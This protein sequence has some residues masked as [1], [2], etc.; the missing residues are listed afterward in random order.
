M[1]SL[2]TKLFAGLVAILVG[3]LVYFSISGG[4]K[5]PSM[6]VELKSG[7]QV[8]LNLPKKPILVNFWATSCPSCVAKMP[9]MAKL[10]EEFG[11]RFEILAI[12]MDYDPKNQVDAF[13]R[14]NPYPFNFIQDSDGSLSEAFGQIRLTPTTFLIAPN[15]NIVYR[16]IGDSDFEFLRQRIDQL[17]PQF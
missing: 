12:S 4:E 6:Q 7:E 17:S 9:D 16:K 5:A 14:A 8:N 10:K 1:K 15:G 13:V 3:A 11:D 2:S